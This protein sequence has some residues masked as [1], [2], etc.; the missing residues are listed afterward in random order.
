MVERK[1]GLLFLWEL[2]VCKRLVGV[3]S[4]KDEKRKSPAIQDE[5]E[6]SSEIK[7]VKRKK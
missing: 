6:V 1:F 2:E 4:G 7:V 5:R 3:F